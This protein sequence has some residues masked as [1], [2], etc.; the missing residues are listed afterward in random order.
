MLRRS[1]LSV[2]TGAALV[3]LGGCTQ[4][5][6]VRVDSAVPEA[7]VARLPV[8]VGVYYDP[9]FSGHVYRESSEDRPDWTIETGPSQQAL[10]DR[11]LGAMF[12]QVVPI[13][14][15]PGPQAPA[16]GVAAV[17]V[18]AI[19]EVQFATPAETRLDFYEAW[20]KYRVE[21][22]APDGTPLGDWEFASY[23][24]T[25][26]AFMTGMDQGLNDA[27]ANALR[28][29]GAKLTVGFGQVPQIKAW[30]DGIARDR[31]AGGA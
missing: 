29:A 4:T 30:L 25:E 10:F 1:A 23:G 22:V 21:L 11:V 15:R 26:K 28:D 7:L 31:Q 13:E 14:R 9:A 16:R 5:V 24:K 8:T 17:I 19:E 6:A 3:V 2:L 12:E 27:V 18:P 20:I